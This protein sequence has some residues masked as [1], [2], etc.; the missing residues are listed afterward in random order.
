VTFSATPDVGAT[1]DASAH[2]IPQV[3]L[4]LNALGGAASASVFLDFDA[5]LGLQGS[6]SSAANPQPCLSG[7][8][9]INVGVG[10]Q[11]SF[12]GLFDASTGKSLFEKDFPLF[13][14][15]VYY[16]P[17]CILPFFFSLESNIY[18]SFYATMIAMLRR[19]VELDE[20][21]VVPVWRAKRNFDRFG[22][23]DQRDQCQLDRSRFSD[24]RDQR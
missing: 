12:F 3:S 21:D 23:A 10:A 8:A 20:F 7:N 5:S 15:R 14:V 19:E 24:H 16:S 6:V 13:Q 4:G 17:Y 2:L 11:G 18:R 22:S 9:D 1:L